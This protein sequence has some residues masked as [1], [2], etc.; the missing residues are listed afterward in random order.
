MA[1]AIVLATALVGP[2]SAAQD[3]VQTFELSLNN[4]K[5]ARADNVIRVTKG[6]I[7]RLRWKSDTVTVVHLHGYDIETTLGPGEI[8]EMS[9]TAYATGRFPVS[10]H[11]SDDP[12]DSHH[13]GGAFLYIEVLPR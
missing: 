4:G 11:R 10:I 12:G 2:S 6:D 7:V 8:T 9:L 13:H 1:L 3:N 5:L